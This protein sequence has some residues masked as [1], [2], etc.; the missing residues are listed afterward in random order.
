MSGTLEEAVQ[1]VFALIGQGMRL[2]I[3]HDGGSP[4]IVDGYRKFGSDKP[5]VE[6]APEVAEAAIR[7]GL[8]HK[9]TEHDIGQRTGWRNA[10]YDGDVADWYVLV[11]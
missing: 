1:T 9:F 6:V 10:E 3:P 5:S 2:R 4:E 8:L 11:Q 7:S